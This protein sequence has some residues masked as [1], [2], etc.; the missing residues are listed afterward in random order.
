MQSARGIIL[1]HGT[2]PLSCA[3]LLPQTNLKL[4]VT[5]NDWYCY[6]LFKV[7]RDH[8]SMWQHLYSMPHARSGQISWAST[9]LAVVIFEA[10][11]VRATKIRTR[12]HTLHSE[13]PVSLRPL[14]EVAVR[15]PD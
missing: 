5:R 9:P 11:R 13:D 6:G 2:C 4:N 10:H 7:S 14:T 15:I 12:R 3:L 8:S 1:I